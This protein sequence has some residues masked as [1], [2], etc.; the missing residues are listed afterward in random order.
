MSFISERSEDET[1]AMK[2]S[3]AHSGIAVAPANAAHLA[4][5]LDFEAELEPPSSKNFGGSAD[6][7]RMDEVK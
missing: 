6:F 2:R 5:G 7:T 1:V 4:S 3:V